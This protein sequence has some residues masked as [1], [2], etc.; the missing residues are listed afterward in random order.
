M[1][2]RSVVVK[3]TA[4]ISVHDWSVVLEEEESRR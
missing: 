4:V 2:V 1:V 3:K